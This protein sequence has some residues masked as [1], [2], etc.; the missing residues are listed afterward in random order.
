[1]TEYDQLPD[2]VRGLEQTVEQLRQGQRHAAR[3]ITELDNRITDMQNLLYEQAKPL[4]SAAL[5][6]ILVELAH[7]ASENQL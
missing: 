3:A 7:R 5:S 2:T 1:M 6:E 4:S